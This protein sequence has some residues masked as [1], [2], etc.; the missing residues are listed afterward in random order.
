MKSDC[1]SMILVDHL[2]LPTCNILHIEWIYAMHCVAHLMEVIA[3]CWA[4]SVPK[5][6]QTKD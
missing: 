6:P 4:F 5:W 3:G 2:Y 1:Q